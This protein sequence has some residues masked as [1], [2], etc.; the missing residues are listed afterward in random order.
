MEVN[1]IL[2]FIVGFSIAITLW[3]AI[4]VLPIKYNR[5]LVG[6]CLL[7]LTLIGIMLLVQPEQAGVVGA[8]G[9]LIFVFIPA[10]GRRLVE[11]LVNGE[12]YPQAIRLA[13]ILRFLHPVDDY[14]ASPDILQ[15]LLLDWKGDNEAAIAILKRYESHPVVGNYVNTRMMRMQYRYQELLNWLETSVKSSELEHDPSLIENY[16]TALA[17]TGQLSRMIHEF[18][19]LLPTL[20]RAQFYLNV[21]YLRLFASTG[22]RE[23][24]EQLLSGILRNAD[25]TTKQLWRA[26]MEM[27]AGNIETGNNYLQE[28]SALPD[29]GVQNLT[30]Y[31]SQHPPI[32][33]HE[34]LTPEDHL[35]LASIQKTFTQYQDYERNATLLRNRRPY[36]TWIILALNMAMFALEIQRG[37]SENPETLYQL[38]ALWTP[39]VLVGG[40][41]WRA[42]TALFLHFGLVHIALNMLALYIL[43]PFLERMFGTLKYT[44]IYLVSGIGSML[45]VLALTQAKMF[46]P[47][48][49]VGASGAIMG[50]V[51]ATAA[52]YLRDWRVEQSQLARKRLLQPVFIVITQVGFDFLVPQTS[53]AGHLSGAFLGFV[54]GLTILFFTHPKASVPAQNLTTQPIPHDA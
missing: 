35:L 50:L 3:R 8:I 53:L 51:G 7:V 10:Q 27:A 21:S 54:F 18:Q 19:R 1:P 46:E 5:G 25:S 24:I 16:I 52:L 15:S 9:W 22:Q 12:R 31:W 2:L 13:K 37:G 41:W 6:L 28:L 47:S 49:M 4:F 33:A 29:S 17:Q 44:L 23:P 36:A 34:V 43:G 30:N 40:E 11:F 20:N 48:L 38:G 32:I 26:I 14:V 42:I 39:A 45:T